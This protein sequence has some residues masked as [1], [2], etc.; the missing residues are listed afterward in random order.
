MGSGPEATV[1]HELDEIF[2]P[3][4]SHNFPEEDEDPAYVN[5]MMIK[6]EVRELKET[7]RLLEACQK[8]GKEG[9]SRTLSKEGIREREMR[10][11]CM[12]ENI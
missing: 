4:M 10:Q 8:R 3:T 7:R 11:S 1:M 6:E 5:R 12:A 9:K 2:S